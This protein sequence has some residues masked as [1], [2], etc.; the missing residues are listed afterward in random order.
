MSDSSG[1]IRVVHGSRIASASRL[2]ESAEGLERI[3]NGALD[4]A[5]RAGGAWGTPERPGA[6]FDIEFAGLTELT[7]NA[8]GAMARSLRDHAAGAELSERTYARAEQAGIESA[9]R[10]RAGLE[11]SR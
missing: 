9:G 7:R 10:L 2:R 4:R 11:G 5:G 3:L 8:F 1:E 6:E